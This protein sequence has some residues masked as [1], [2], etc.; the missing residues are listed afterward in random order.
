[1]M[2]KA[3]IFDCDGT[4]VDTEFLSAVSYTDAI[5]KYH[6]NIAPDQFQ[7]EFLGVTN[8]SIAGVLGAR[9]GLTLPVDAI[10]EDYK[11]NMSA[12]MGT[13]MQVIPE[14][15]AYVRD[16]SS[17]CK[18]AVGSNGTRSVVIEELQVAGYMDF[19]KENQICTA[20]QVPYP[21]PAPDLFLF[22]ALSLGVLPA[23]CWVIEDSVVGTRAGV[24]AG[25]KVLGYTGFAHDP[26]AAALALEKAGCAAIINSL[27]EIDPFL[28]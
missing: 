3:V 8:S 26:A 20:S 9:Y 18:I 24:A 1:M 17:R 21:K 5:K 27:S 4:L 12:N 2:A 25:M 7:A 28:S 23:D 16:L 11:K 19:L 15:L 13:Y 10:N 14:S 22:A 6:I